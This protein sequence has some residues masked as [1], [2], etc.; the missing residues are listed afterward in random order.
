M[1]QINHEEL[2]K[3][4]GSSG[5]NMQNIDSDTLPPAN[6]IIAGVA[7]TGKSTLINAVFGKELA[8]TGT[9]SSVTQ[10]I[11]RYHAPGV[12][13]NILDTVG[14]ELD[15]KKREESITNIKK[16]ISEKTTSKNAFDYIHAI[17]YC[18][19][20]GSHRYQEAE[21][22]F[23]SSLFSLGVPFIVVMTK[24][25]SGEEDDA[26]ESEVQKINKA[27]GMNN[28]DIVQVLAKEYSTKLGPIPS[29]GLDKLI[30][31]TTEK[32]PEFI[33]SGFIAAQRV[34]K[35]EKRRI[36]ENI[37]FEYVKAAKEGFWDKVP[38]I[39]WFTTDSKII[40][41]FKKIGTLYNAVLPEDSI[42][43]V[44]ESCKI[45]FGNIFDGLINPFDSAYQK[46]VAKFLGEMKE[47]DGFD[48]KTS[49]FTSSERAA[50]MI[51]FYGYT[52]IMSMEEVWT[53]LTE[54]ELKNVEL[55]VR[56]LIAKINER[57]VSIKGRRYGI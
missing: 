26:F 53:E 56:K 10:K 51:A 40:N 37:V 25:V 27:N 5:V 48:V 8:K 1:A 18:I 23:V 19:G 32:L 17:W 14:F 34:D 2:K 9:G 49:E 47:K 38:I 52:F 3:Q 30:K 45:D 20:A 13:V 31:I 55:V 7:G 24:C 35:V 36:C 33:K 29:F 41:M 42:K 22:K 21:A 6:I 28:I 54:E 12:P 39:N 44:T 50:R 15:E 11:T 16:A 4:M 46:K 43:R 57:L